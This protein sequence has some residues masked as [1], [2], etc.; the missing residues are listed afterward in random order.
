MLSVGTVLVEGRVGA[1]TFVTGD[2]ARLRSDLVSPLAVQLR[3][4]LDDATAAGL[5]RH[6]VLALVNTL[7]DEHEKLD[8]HDLDE[9]EKESVG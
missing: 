3:G 6:E 4:W 5:A 7:L 8:G 1:G 2:L 9:H